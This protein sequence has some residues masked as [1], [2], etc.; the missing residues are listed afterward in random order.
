M[1]PKSSAKCRGKQDQVQDQ[2]RHQ[3]Q[4]KD[5]D[6]GAITTEPHTS[7]ACNKD[8]VMLQRP[9]SAGAAALAL[10]AAAVVLLGGVLLW[11]VGG[12]LAM[13]DAAAM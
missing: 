5:Q 2:S 9:T 8:Q 13:G 4:G 10:V 1:L 12:G 7:R 3:G 11:V 6:H